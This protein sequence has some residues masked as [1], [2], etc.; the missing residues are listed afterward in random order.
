[1]D[2]LGPHL[3]LLFFSFPSSFSPPF[4]PYVHINN[5][6]FDLIPCDEQRQLLITVAN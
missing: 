4:L 6:D 1:M 5:Q 2:Y 3:K